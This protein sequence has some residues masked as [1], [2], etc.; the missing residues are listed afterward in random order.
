[1]NRK[2]YSVII[3]LYTIINIVALVSFNI[4]NGLKSK[5]IN[6]I[7]KQSE[8]YNDVKNGSNEQDDYKDN[9][10][11]EKSEDI[12]AK[13]DEVSNNATAKQRVKANRERQYQL[14]EGYEDD[15]KIVEVNEA[16]FDKYN[17]E[18][19]EKN[20]VMKVPADELINKLTILEKAKIMSICKELDEND[21]SDITEFLTYKN[22]KLAVIKTLGVIESKVDEE[23]VEE[24][25]EI[26]SKY[27]DMKKVEGD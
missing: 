7:S 13:D 25:K 2:L 15:G 11:S 26:F 5:E 6:N 14:D 12:Q 10:I 21:Y 19:R 9:N 4:N 27:I 18:I 16:D 1:M 24:L 3:V 8:A 22:E 23:E 17:K 20:K